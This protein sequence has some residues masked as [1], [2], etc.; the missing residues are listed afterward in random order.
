M[1]RRSFSPRQHPWTPPRHYNNTE[2]ICTTKFSNRSGYLPCFGRGQPLTFEIHHDAGDVVVAPSDV[3][4]VDQSIHELRQWAN[5]GHL[6]FD[7]GVLNK[8]AQAIG[9]KKHPVASPEL[10][11]CE[12]NDHLLGR[13]KRLKNDIGVFEHL[14]FVFGELACFDQLIDE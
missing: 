4:K 12:V 7:G 5:S 11:E 13:A 8:A 1:R 3:C 9:A 6:R 10:D 14:G 2:Y